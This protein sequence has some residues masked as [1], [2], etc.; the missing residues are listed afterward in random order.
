ML[1]IKGKLFLAPMA[2][3]TDKVF[4]SLCSRFGADVTVTEMVSAKAI[5]MGSQKTKELISFSEDEKIK[6]VQIFGSDPHVMAEAV[7]IIQDEFEYDFID[8]NMGCPVPKV[9][10]SGEGSALMKNPSLAAKIVEEVAKVSRK[11]VSVKI[12]KGFDEENINAPEFACI[13]QESGASF[14]T[15]HGRT[16]TQMYSGKADWEIIK[17]VKEKVKIPVVANGDIVDFESAKKAYEI[18]EADS[19]MI[20]RAALGNPWVFLQIKEGFENGQVTTRVLP[21]EKV[22]VAIEFFRQLCTEKSEKMAVLEA[23]K[24]LSFFIKGIENAAKIRDKINRIDNAEILISYLEQLKAELEQKL[25]KV[26]NI[27]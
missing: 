13:M 27:L 11:P 19:I 23:R 6:G 2:G 20:G 22:K 8:I 7:K 3:F 15:V 16:R 26:D 1:N 25:K 18:T 14:I 12:R 24:H 5:T 21:H 4:R 17:M 10:K 9:V